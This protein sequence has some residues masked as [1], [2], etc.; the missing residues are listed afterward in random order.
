MLHSILSSCH[1]SHTALLAHCLIQLL[2]LLS[3]HCNIARFFHLLSSSPL[4]VFSSSPSV[5]TDWLA[6]TLSTIASHSHSLSLFACSSLPPSPLWTMVP[7]V[8]SHYHHGWMFS[9]VFLFRHLYIRLTF[10]CKSLLSRYSTDYSLQSNSCESSCH[11]HK[12]IWPN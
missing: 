9:L 11:T 3:Y 8:S 1:G 12:C 6:S 7:Q 4:L 2:I 5:G 10:Y